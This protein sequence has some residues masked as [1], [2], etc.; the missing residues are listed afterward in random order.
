MTTTSTLVDDQPRSIAAP[1]HVHAAARAESGTTPPRRTSWAPRT[2][3]HTRS[4]GD[5]LYGVAIVAVIAA[6]VASIAFLTAYEP[7]G[8]DVTTMSWPAAAAGM[9]GVFSA[10]AGLVIA[11]VASVRSDPTDRPGR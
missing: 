6:F 3:R 10:V 7:G 9:V 2:H 11:F 4:V 5:A 8:A 1:H